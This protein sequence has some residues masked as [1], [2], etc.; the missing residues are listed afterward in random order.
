MFNKI[1]TVFCLSVFCFSLLTATGCKLF[2]SKSKVQRT[3]TE[4]QQVVQQE[5]VQDQGQEL[6]EKI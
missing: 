4:T 3:M 5:R 1:L 2:K 6:I